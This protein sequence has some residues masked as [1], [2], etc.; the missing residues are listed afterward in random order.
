[1]FTAL[2]GINMKNV[3]YMS[4]EAWNDLPSTTL[5]QVL[6]QIVKND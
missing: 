6:E 5:I 2:K 3:V 1:M 4:A